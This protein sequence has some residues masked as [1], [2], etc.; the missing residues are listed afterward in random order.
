MQHRAKSRKIVVHYLTGSFFCD[1][2]R[3]PAKKM[4][5]ANMKKKRNILLSFPLKS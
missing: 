3:E 1:V 2:P 4:V 5:K